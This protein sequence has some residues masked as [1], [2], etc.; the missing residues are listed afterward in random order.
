[1]DILAQTILFFA[2]LA[3]TANVLIVMLTSYELKT[4]IQ[5]RL[6]IDRS[7]K[8]EKKSLFIVILDLFVPVNYMIINRF[9]KREKM[10]EK[11]FA[12]RVFIMPE[13]FLTIKQ[14]MAFAFLFL[15]FMFVQSGDMAPLVILPLIGFFAPNMWLN[16]K[17]KKRKAQ[18]ERSLPDVVDLLSLCV[19]AG[20]DFMAAA[21]WIVEKSLQNAFTE[22]MSLVLHEIKV[23]KSRRDALKDMS[24]RLNLTDVTAFCRTLIQA[25]R[26]GIPIAEALSILSEDVRERFFRRAE[27]KAL[28]A[29]MKML[30]PLIFFILPVVGVIVGGPVLLQFMSGG[31]GGLK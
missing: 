18:I 15:T 1:M 16:L 17:I 13:Q 2:I 19:D 4:A 12:A 22:E 29:P 27:R 28:Q 3:L 24:K 23:G 11:L 9:F 10:D 26:M 21:R 31:L 5:R 6:R 14:L 7:G 20:L 8:E 30:L 25:D